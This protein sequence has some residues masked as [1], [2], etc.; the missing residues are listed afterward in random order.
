[1]AW[2]SGVPRICRPFS[3]AAPQ[4]YP[5]RGSGRR[6]GTLWAWLG[7]MAYRTQVANPALK[8]AAVV[9]CVCCVSTWL[10]LCGCCVS[11]VPL[12]FQHMAWGSGVPR[13]CR[14]FPAAAPQRYPKRGSGRRFGTLWSWLGA[15][16]YRAQVANP[17]LK[18]SRCLTERLWRV[19]R[20]GCVL[21]QVDASPAIHDVPWPSYTHGPI[22]LCVCCVSTWLV[23]CVCCVSTVP[24]EF[25]HMA[26]GSGVPRA[27]RPFPAA[28][29]QRYPKRGS[30]R[31]F[32]TLWSWLGAMAYR[33]QVANPTLK[34]SRCLTERLWRVAR[35]GC[36]LTQL[37]ASPASHDVPWP[38]YTHGPI[39]LCVCCVSTCSAVRVLRVY[40]ACAVRVLRV[41]SLSRVPAHGLGEWGSASLSAIFRS[42][43]TVLPKAGLRPPLWNPVVLA[44]GNGLQIACCE[45][46][47]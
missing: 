32:G 40:M 2:V 24:L 30:G 26:W 22:V 11:T 16:A 46:H 20:G 7:A 31:R 29:P 44:G 45:P 41:Y 1:M 34:Q 9:L 8:Q 3:A 35:G 42:S 18:Q 15:M 33:A 17:T 23:L 37:D 25:Q 38:S 27:C 43:I 6:F 36:V 21:T 47:S 39:V 4:R 13:A 5:K 19:A 28:A 14:P 12:E 10:V